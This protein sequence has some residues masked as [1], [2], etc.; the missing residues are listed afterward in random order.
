MHETL[1]TRYS[2][3]FHLKDLLRRDV[4]TVAEIAKWLESRAETNRDRA[5]RTGSKRMMARL[6]AAQTLLKAASGDTQATESLMNR[7][8]G[9]V[10]DKII[11]LDGNRLIEQLE[12]A[13][14]R[15]LSHDNRITVSQQVIE[16]Q[17]VSDHALDTGSSGCVPDSRVGRP[18]QESNQVPSGR[19]GSM[20]ISP[21][22]S[23]AE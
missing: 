20:S 18:P 5:N 19:V 9:K 23:E 6:I 2:V 14:Q 4:Q 17:V 3:S 8:E 13:R 7:T 10:A 22:E 15:V 12:A 16:G 11:S 1:K 21:P